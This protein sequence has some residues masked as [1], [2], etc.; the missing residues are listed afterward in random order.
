M[1]G[2]GDGC[3]FFFNKRLSKLNLPQ[4]SCRK[5]KLHQK[6]TFYSLFNYFTPLIPMAGVWQWLHLFL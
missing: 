1:A 4:A 3:T 6:E 5:K 2:V